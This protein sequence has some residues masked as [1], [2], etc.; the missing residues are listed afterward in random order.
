MDFY[1]TYEMLDNDDKQTYRIGAKLLADFKAVTTNQA[2]TIRKLM[3]Q[4]IHDEMHGITKTPKAEDFYKF[5]LEYEEEKRTKLLAV[6]LPKQ[7]L[8]A[9]KIATPK[10]SKTIR[11]L[12]IIYI[13]EH[14][15]MLPD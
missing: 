4:Y 11:L 14:R 12:M 8:D 10:Q 6:K 7:L 13:Y 2:K 3:I 15:H 9:F 5:F 1:N